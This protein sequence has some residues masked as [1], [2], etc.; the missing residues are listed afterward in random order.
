MVNYPS[1]Q[2]PKRIN[3]KVLFFEVCLQFLIRF[4][5][6]RH[7]KNKTLSK[8]H[9]SNDYLELRTPEVVKILSHTSVTPPHRTKESPKTSHPMNP[10]SQ[11]YCSKHMPAALLAQIPPHCHQD[12]KKLLLT[13]LSHSSLSAKTPQQQ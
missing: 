4:S 1:S 8:C 5:N 9:F 13:P 10:N 7:Y 6:S 3:G 12:W 2:L 11:N